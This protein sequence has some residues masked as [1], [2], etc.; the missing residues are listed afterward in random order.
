VVGASVVEHN[1]LLYCPKLFELHV[2]LSPV[3][4]FLQLLRLLISFLPLLLQPLLFS[5]LVLL[6]IYDGI[7]LFWRLVLLPLPSPLFLLRL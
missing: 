2:L 5:S 1:L 6:A 4:F 7:L 3:I